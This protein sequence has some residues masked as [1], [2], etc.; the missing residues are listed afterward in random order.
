MGGCLVPCVQSGLV[1]LSNYVRA[2][3]LI[4]LLNVVAGDL[5]SSCLEDQLVLGVV[6]AELQ[7]QDLPRHGNNL[8]GHNTTL[9]VGHHIVLILH[10]HSHILGGSVSQRI[11]KGHHEVIG[12]VLGE[13]ALTNVQ[14]QAAFELA[15]GLIGQN[16]QS[17]ASG[18]GTT[19]NGVV[20]ETIVVIGHFLLLST[21]DGIVVLHYSHY[22]AQIVQVLGLL[23]TGEVGQHTQLLGH[24]EDVVA[25]AF[26]SL[27]GGSGSEES[28]PETL[29]LVGVRQEVL[30]LIWEALKALMQR[31]QVTARGG[32]DEVVLGS[33]SLAFVDV[34]ENGPQLAP[35]IFEVLDPTYLISLSMFS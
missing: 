31:V 26:K 9:G 35:I 30:C 6:A 17:I 28:G 2:F 32:V 34:P 14:S 3:F 10:R 33:T 13:G 4:N 1:I 24:L 20:H 18:I 25:I 7:G 8:R 23:L 19:Q 16:P 12:I 15:V 27:G 22:L 21:S 5:F 11:V 29:R